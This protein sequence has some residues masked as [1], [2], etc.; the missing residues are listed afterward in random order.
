MLGTLNQRNVRLEY[1]YNVN[2][3]YSCR[4]GFSIDILKSSPVSPLLENPIYQFLR[5][6]IR[7]LHFQPYVTSA[8]LKSTFRL[9]YISSRETKINKQPICH[10]I[11]KFRNK[12]GAIIAFEVEKYI[13]QY[14]SSDVSQDFIFWTIFQHHEDFSNYD[15]D[16]CIYFF[17]IFKSL[18]HT[19]GCFIDRSLTSL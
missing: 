4:F 18:Q 14:K 17:L 3:L 1:Q 19:A 7:Y 16:K 6:P 5:A 10:K 9:V 12:T 11:I 2:K 15:E 13:L 8:N